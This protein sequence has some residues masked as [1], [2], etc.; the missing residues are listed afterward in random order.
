MICYWKYGSDQNNQQ[1]SILHSGEISAKICKGV[2]EN[3]G[4]DVTLPSKSA[5]LSQQFCTCLL[6]FLSKLRF[7]FLETFRRTKRR[8]IRLIESNAKCR[9]LKKITCKGTL[10]QVFIRLRPPPLLGFV[11]NGKVILQVLNLVRNRAVNSLQNMVSTQLKTRN[12]SP[13]H[14]LSV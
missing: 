6:N 2:K 13:S 12:P 10:R 14:T 3:F 9:Y 5:N 8:E 1:Y 4:S 7:L 11:L